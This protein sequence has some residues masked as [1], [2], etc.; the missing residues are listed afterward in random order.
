MPFVPD[1]YELLMAWLDRQAKDYLAKTILAKSMM[2]TCALIL[3]SIL[4]MI[5]LSSRRPT[6]L[7]AT[8]EPHCR[9][10]SKTNRLSSVSLSQHYKP[11]LIGSFA[12]RTTLPIAS[13]ST[14]K[15]CVPIWSANGS[16]KFQH[17]KC[18][19]SSITGSNSI[20]AA[21]RQSR[22]A[23]MVPRELSRRIIG[24]VTVSC[25]RLLVANSTIDRFLSRSRSNIALPILK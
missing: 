13:H 18:R 24:R 5:K 20:K 19:L 1:G 14:K 16:S 15:E 22:L 4:G 12:R 17:S 2:T 11:T 8:S 3:I 10:G 23:L 6:A 21:L 25:A 9:P 7:P